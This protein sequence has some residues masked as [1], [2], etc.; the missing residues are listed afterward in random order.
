MGYVSMFAQNQTLNNLSSASQP[1][2]DADLFLIFQTT[3]PLKK[4]TFDNLQEDVLEGVSLSSQGSGTSNES[5]FFGYQ[6]GLSYS[7]GNANIGIGTEALKVLN[8]GD[9]NIGLGYQAGTA[10]TSGDNN[11]FMGYQAGKAVTTP[12]GLIFIGHQAGLL[13]TTGKWNIFIGASAGAANVTG[14]KNIFIGS[15]AG[16]TFT[17][18]GNTYIGY[19]GAESGGPDGYGNIFVG[20]DVAREASTVNYSIAIGDS[21]GYQMANDFNTFIGHK[22]GYGTTTNEASTYIGYHSGMNNNGLYSLFAGAFSGFTATA[23]HRVVA[24]GYQAGYALTVGTDN[25]LI[26]YQ[27]GLGMT[28]T[29]GS[30]GIG[31]QAGKTISTTIGTFIGYQAGELTTGD[32]CTFIGY[33]SGDINSTGANNIGLGENTLGANQ[34]GTDNTAIGFNALAACTSNQNTAV[35][36]L[37]GDGATGIAGCVYLGYSAGR[38]NTTANTLYIENSNTLTDVLIFGDFSGDEVIIDGQAS[39]N[40]NSRNFYVDGDAGGDGAW[41]NDSDSTLKKDIET[42]PDALERVMNLRGVTFAWKDGREDKRRMGF[43]AQE[44]QEFIPEVVDGVEGSMSIQYAPVVALLTEAIQ[45]QQS[46]IN[47]LSTMLIC[48]GLLIVV[49]FGL[50]IY[51]L[52]RK[53]NYLKIAK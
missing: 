8:S 33:G 24:L 37:A 30:I 12:T 2:N 52:L 11:V 22:A 41:N 50:I 5:V 1:L 44:A 25:V 53:T 28:S 3:N 46:Q 49:C 47:R 17:G 27:A 29:V 43:L 19:N 18:S 23:A 6:S 31:Y 26:G 4:Y 40:T 9:Y 21:A 39:D 45:E 16:Y 36:S 34:T 10:V 51:I 38:T 48:M 42:I 13:N 32:N 7:A 15:Q 35:G 14:E 20:T